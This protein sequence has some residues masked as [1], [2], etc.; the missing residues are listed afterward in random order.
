MSNNSRLKNF[1][2][3][4]Y[5]ITQQLSNIIKSNDDVKVVSRKLNGLLDDHK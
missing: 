1:Q 5:F 4:P 2:N 3:V